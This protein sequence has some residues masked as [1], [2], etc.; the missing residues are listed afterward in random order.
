MVPGWAK[1]KL[2]AHAQAI[3]KAPTGGKGVQNQ[4]FW[5]DL[6]DAFAHVSLITHRKDGADARS[7]RSSSLLWPIDQ[8]DMLENEWAIAVAKVVPGARPM[9]PDREGLV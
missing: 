1:Q 5:L 3:V 9:H 6:I 4:P 7:Y 2:D 8:V